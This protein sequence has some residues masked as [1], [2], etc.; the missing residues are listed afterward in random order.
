M[1]PVKERSCSTVA[2]A[3]VADS[4]LELQGLD[5][6]ILVPYNSH[7][8]ALAHEQDSEGRKCKREEERERKM[9]RKSWKG[10][11]KQQ[12]ITTKVVRM[13]EE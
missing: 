1:M 10:E 13:E 8:P 9:R 12:I 4:S 3:V 5:S 2:A 11:E 7:F 6:G